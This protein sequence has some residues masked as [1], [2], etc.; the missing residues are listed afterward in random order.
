MSFWDSMAARSSRK[1]R[2]TKTYTRAPSFTSLTY[3]QRKSLTI[4]ES[5]MTQ[6]AK[7][8]MTASTRKLTQSLGQHLPS[9][10]KL[11]PVTL[12]TAMLILPRTNRT[13][14]TT[15]P[16]PSCKNTGYKCNNS[17]RQAVRF[18][19]PRT[20]W[21]RSTTTAAVRRSPAM[22]M[23]QP[24]DSRT[25]ASRDKP[26]L[27]RSSSRSKKKKSQDRIQSKAQ[28][29]KIETKTKIQ[30]KTRTTPWNKRWTTSIS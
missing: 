7:L 12:R 22:M 19:I 25:F 26:T 18:G 17:K 28:K 14:W 8:K 23:L 2:K 15:V 6:V 10:K 20:R 16:T 11:L 9:R 29:K 13:P 24:R 1:M 4:K 21:P 30:M 5:P 27:R 3:K